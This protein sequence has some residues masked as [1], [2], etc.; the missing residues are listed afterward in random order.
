MHAA[1]T[2]ASSSI[3]LQQNRGA[4]V[5]LT[6]IKCTSA[7]QRAEHLAEARG[8]AP[9]GVDGDEQLLPRQGQGRHRRGSMTGGW[10]QAGSALAQNG[11]A[12]TQINSL[13]LLRKRSRS[14]RRRRLKKSGNIRLRCSCS[15]KLLSAHKHRARVQS[16]AQPLPRKQTTAHP[17][18]SHTRA[19]SAPRSPPPTQKKQKTR[20][21]PPSVASKS[22]RRRA[23]P[24]RWAA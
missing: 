10:G 1:L 17:L 14:S 9:H 23:L 2:Q 7:L 20:W 18:L 21:A 8:T 16:F 6:F 3:P 11:C 4:K 12:S 22:T 13:F 5:A 19:H 24:S 15:A